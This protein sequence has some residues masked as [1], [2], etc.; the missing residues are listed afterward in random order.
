MARKKHLDLCL[1][2]CFLVLLLF[3]KGDLTQSRGVERSPSSRKPSPTSSFFFFF[4]KPRSIPANQLELPTIITL[5]TRHLFYL[6]L[7]LPPS[8]RHCAF[9]SLRI[10]PCR[11]LLSI[12]S[13]RDK[14]RVLNTQSFIY[15]YIPAFVHL[16]HDECHKVPCVVLGAQNNN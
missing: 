4:F 15:L 7:C 14:R 8:L 1:P 12:E 9:R 16:T 3:I 13:S 11:V 5:L 10:G 6:L 2:I